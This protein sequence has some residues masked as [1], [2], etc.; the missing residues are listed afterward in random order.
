MADFV[1]A[2]NARLTQRTYNLQA[3][4]FT[5]G[6]IAAAIKKRIPSFRIVYEPDFRQAIA[7][8]WPKVLDDSK[9]WREKERGACVCLPACPFSLA[10]SDSL[11]PHSLAHS[12]P[13]FSPFPTM[14]PSQARKDWDWQHEY[15]VENTVDYMLTELTKLNNAAR[16]PAAAKL[17]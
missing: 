17:A 11:H 16:P 5:P 6:E 15:D 12:S 8:S 14:S 2:D 13:S 1:C 3:M 4:S 9:V 7:A 10:F